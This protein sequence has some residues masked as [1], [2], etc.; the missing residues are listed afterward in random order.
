VTNTYLPISERAKTLLGENVVD[1]DLTATEEKDQLDAGHLQIVP[2]AY[3]VLSNNFS[4]AEQGK[5]FEAAYPVETEAALIQGGHIE[6][7]EKPA[8]KRK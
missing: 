5:S 1:L 3:K 6:R 2:R 8:S 7:V 4:A